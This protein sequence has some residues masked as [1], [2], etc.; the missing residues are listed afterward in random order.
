MAKYG[1][2]RGIRGSEARYISTSEY[3]RNLFME[4]EQLEENIVQC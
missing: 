4:S 1:L 2:Q 3:Y